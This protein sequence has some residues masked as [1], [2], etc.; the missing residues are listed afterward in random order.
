MCQISEIGV[1]TV[2]QRKQR[3]GPE[4]VTELVFEYLARSKAL[5]IPQWNPCSNP[6]RG[7]VIIPIL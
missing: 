7:V 5:N 2:W 1:Y 4:K 6:G 3:V